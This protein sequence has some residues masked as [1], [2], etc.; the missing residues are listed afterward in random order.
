MI[1]G[2][3]QWED[4]QILFHREIKPFVAHQCNSEYDPNSQT[5]DEGPQLVGQTVWST[6]SCI[7]NQI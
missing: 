4:L 3:W 7:T 1:Q 6:P 5:T 2:K